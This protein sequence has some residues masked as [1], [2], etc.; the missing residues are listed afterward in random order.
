MSFISVLEFT[1]KEIL[2]S[3][4]DIDE[5]V[6][7]ICLKIKAKLENALEEYEI[8]AITN[9]GIIPATMVSYNLGIKNINLFP[10]IDKKVIH[11]KIPQFDAA[12]KYLLIDEIYDTGKTL[13]KTSICL[14]HV[15]HLN[16][17]L[18]ERHKTASSTDR[19]IG[20]TLEDSRW[21]VFPWEKPKKQT[22]KS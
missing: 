20:K 13:G 2:L 11:S 9:G 14:G 17:F 6:E 5:L 4:G 1:S 12:K 3:W 8:I 19:I 22:D 10:M 18:V 16:V 15:N 7:N 21:V